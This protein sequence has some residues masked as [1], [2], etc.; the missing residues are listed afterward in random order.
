M[1]ERIKKIMI[2]I[3]FILS[4]IGIGAAL[5]FAFFRP[6]TPTPPTVQPTEDETEQIGGLIGSEEGVPDYVID[7]VQPLLLTADS[8]AKGSDTQTR[9]LTVGKA[10]HTVLSKNGLSINYHNASD[11]RFYTID[12]DGNTVKLSNKKFPNV[13]N[14]SWNRN[15]S[16]AVLEFPDGSN[17]IY[18]FD[19][20]Q[21]VTLPKHWEDFGFSPVRDQ[22][23]AKSIGLDP[24][25]RWLVSA[26]DDGSR[27]K[28]IAALG[29]NEHKVQVNW[30]P[31]DQVVAFADTAKESLSGDIDRKMIFPI[32]KNKENYKGL[33]VEGIN[34]ESK[35]SPSGKKLL[36]SVSGS[37]SEYKPLLWI[38]DATPS[39]MGK[40]R[41]S[42]A[43]NTWVEKCTWHDS[44]TVYCAVPIHLPNNAGLMPSMFDYLDDAIYKIKISSG[45]ISKIA[46]PKPA[47]TISEM[48]VS[49]DESTLYYKNLVTEQLEAL[50]LK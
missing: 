20:E 26:N 42:V 50:N 18:D 12:K 17:V 33:T 16:K 45:G 23:L 46:T 10:S 4:V 22:V 1:N 47:V 8:V 7:T 14:V 30:S 35:W 5:F 21:Q 13:E 49:K 36:Y 3:L 48:Y 24:N 29:T 6:S 38:T 32:G 37:Y 34:F 31:N 44:D 15:S 11:G 25:N 9:E 40:N 19:S 27:I 2:I 39:T 41:K 43:L 28:T